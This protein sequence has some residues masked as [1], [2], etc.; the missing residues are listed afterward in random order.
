MSTSPVVRVTH[1]EQ[2]T[3]STLRRQYLAGT[4]EMP[5]VTGEK[6]PTRPAPAS[7]AKSQGPSRLSCLYHLLFRCCLASP[8]LF[9][10]WPGLVL[11][12]KRPIC[13]CLSVYLSIPLMCA[14]LLVL[15]TSPLRNIIWPGNADER[16]TCS[17]LHPSGNEISCLT[18]SK[19]ARP[20]DR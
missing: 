18:W 20:P 4:C 9:V 2:D 12:R 7:A 13:S 10:A 5:G 6:V 17:Y 16:I 15:Y 19:V 14:Q 11:D 3:M 1:Y 8:L